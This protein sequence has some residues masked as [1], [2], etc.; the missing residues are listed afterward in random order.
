MSDGLPLL[1]V[2]EFVLRVQLLRGVL[3]DVVEDEFGSVFGS[4]WVGGGVPF[5]RRSWLRK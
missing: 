3:C 2:L 5:M 4:G 1:I